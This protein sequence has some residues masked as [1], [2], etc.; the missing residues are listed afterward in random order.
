[1]LGGQHYNI[2]VTDPAWHAKLG[3]LSYEDHPR[4]VCGLTASDKLFF[5]I[6]LGK[7]MTS[8]ECFKLVAAV[9]VLPLQ[10]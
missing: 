1:M 7:P 4:N 10:R 2:A 9:V 3:D 6:S 8:G 5:V